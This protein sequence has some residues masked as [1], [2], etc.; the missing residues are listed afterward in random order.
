MAASCTAVKTPE[1]MLDFTVPSALIA[2]A[3]PQANATRQPVMLYAFEQL[4]S[5]MATSL[6]PGRSRKLGGDVAVE[7]DLGVGVVVDDEQVVLLGERDRA[8][9][10]LV[11]GDGRGRVVGVAQ[12]HHL[13]LGEHLG[14]GRLEVGEEA[15]LLGH[16]HPPGLA[17]D[18]DA[19]G[20]VDGVAD[21]GD[22]RVLAGVDERR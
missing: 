5:S 20:V 22:E 14:R 13:G 6:A 17:A 2:C 10:V 12:E 7:A 21:A 1:S 8:I 11:V 3:L 18:H 4:N 9:E 15:V 19:A 16:R